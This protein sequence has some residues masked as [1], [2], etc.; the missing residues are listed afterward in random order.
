MKR[1]LITGAA[2]NLG[3]LARARLGHLAEVLRLSDIADM[4]PAGANEEVVPC[5]LGDEQAVFDLVKPED[6]AGSRQLTLTRL[7]PGATVEEIREKTEA[8]FVV[9]PALAATTTLE[10]AT[11]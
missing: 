9:D 8:E 1:L 4:E 3:K 10:G 5:D 11:A 7:A 6:G 2:G